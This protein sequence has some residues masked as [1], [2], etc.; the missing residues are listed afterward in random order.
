GELSEERAKII[1]EQI[2]Q[3]ALD[4]KLDHLFIDLSGVLTIDTM[5]AHEIIKIVNSLRLLGVKSILTGIRPEISRTIV[6]LGINFET[7][8]RGTLKQAIHEFLTNQKELS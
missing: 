3:K 7:Q 5:V 4:F 1:M 6:N 8:S 2:L